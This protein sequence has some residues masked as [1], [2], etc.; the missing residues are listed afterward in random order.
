M[1]KEEK[2]M[3]NKEEKKIVEA[4]DV[5]VKD[6]IGVDVSE[7]KVEKIEEIK[8]DKKVESKDDKKSD[9]IEHELKDGKIQNKK[10]DVKPDAKKPKK[11]EKK[12]PKKDEAVARGENLHMSKRH[13]MYICSFIKKKKIDEAMR[14]LEEVIKLKRAIPFKGEIP[15]RKGKGMMSGRYPVKAS[16]IFITILKSLKGNTIVNGMDIDNSRIT[17]ASANWDARP[18]RGRGRQA[19]RTNVVL[20]MTEI[21]GGKE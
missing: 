16:K 2:K 12:I 10:E 1:S 18:M 7:N 9:N 4:E 8:D 13:A 6:S 14:D 3:E 11:E 15:H 19:K 5:N 20:K 21:V 17:F